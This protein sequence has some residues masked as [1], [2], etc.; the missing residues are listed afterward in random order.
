MSKINISD[1]VTGAYAVT[2]KKLY[3]KAEM[4]SR[5]YANPM[6]Y[7]VPSSSISCTATLNNSNYL[8]GLITIK[9]SADADAVVVQ[10][11]Q[12]MIL[13]DC[14]EIENTR[15]VSNTA[16]LSTNGC[17]YVFP[18]IRRT[19]DNVITESDISV[20]KNSFALEFEIEDQPVETSDKNLNS[21]TFP[22]LP[23]KYKVAQVADEYNSSSTYAVGD[24][25]NYLGTTYRCTTAITTAENWTSGH[26]TPVKIANEVTELKS[27]IEGIEPGLSDETKEALLAC[28]EHVAWI[29]DD[30]QDYYDA[31][32]EALYPNAVQSITASISLGS[33][34]V[35]TSDNLDTL[36]EYLT[37]TAHYEDGTSGEVTDYILSGD[38]TTEG[39]NVVTVTY[40]NKTAT[41]NVPVVWGYRIT[42]QDDLS[43]GT[44]V[45]TY[46]DW[47]TIH[48]TDPTNT[49]RVCNLS[50]LPWETGYNCYVEADTALNVVVSVNCL[51]QTAMNNVN[52]NQDIN[53]S[54][55]GL[56]GWA[57]S[58]P[59]LSVI[60]DSVNNSPTKAIRVVFKTVPS[61][62]AFSVNDISE[63]RIT[64]RAK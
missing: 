3:Y 44:L 51:N 23:Y 33:H 48:Y 58:N 16:S 18:F 26:W 20:I 8:I 55:V 27:A 12:K 39:T 22:G 36:R 2:D 25:V 42:P 32:E 60:P 31:L 64:R 24:I 46:R 61:E 19:D 40:S 21:I 34:T 14:T 62:T 54:D 59:S 4:Y 35:F 30:G 29:G 17:D 57:S 53:S 43:Q 37:V 10:G 63:V 52:N 15:W 56:P 47:Q 50:F 11:V 1:F 49:K 41:V 6:L 45:Y 5:A 38:I 13:D 9:S 7:K 28:F